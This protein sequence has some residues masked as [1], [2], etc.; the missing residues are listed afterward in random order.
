M[1]N[2]ISLQIFRFLHGKK[3]AQFIVLHENLIL[4]DLNAP[5]NDFYY[6]ILI[7]G[8][9]LRSKFNIIPKVSVDL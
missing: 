1:F 3:K 6:F 8:K 7:K 5:I 4:F 2:I 9:R